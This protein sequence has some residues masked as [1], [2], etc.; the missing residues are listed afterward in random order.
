MLIRYLFFL[1]SFIG[2]SLT[3]CNSSSSSSSNSDSTQIRYSLSGHIL[4]AGNTAKDDDVNDHRAPEALE[5]DTIYTAQ[6]VNN[7]LILGG[8]VNQPWSG[9]SGRSQ[10]SGDVNDF[11][12]VDLRANQTITLFV[13]NENL[14]GNDLDLA[15]LDRNGAILNASV[16][17]G[18]T[19]NI[20][21]PTDGRYFVLVQAHSG[22]SNYVLSIGQTVTTTSR[23]VQITDDF[24]PGEIII[25]FSQDTIYQAQST[26]NTLGMQTQSTD[27]TRP[28]LYTLKK[29]LQSLGHSLSEMAFATPELKKKYETL[30]A[31]K[32][33]RQRPDIEKVYLNYRRK[34]F[35]EP[36]DRLY[37]YQWN[38]SLMNLPQ[39]W[40]TTIGDG[41]VI[42]AVVD[43][44]VLVQ[45]PDLRNQLVQGY[46]FIASRYTELDSD[47]GIDPNPDDPGDQF[48]GGS[49]FHGTHVAG[50]VAAQSNNNEGVAGAA[51]LTKIM[52][53]RVLGKGGMGVDYD[54]EQAIRF[55]AGLPN[56]SGTVPTRRADIINLSLGGP[57]Y[58]AGFQDLMNEV[59]EAGVI[60]VAAS[61]N[62]DTDSPSYPAALNNVISVGAVN[63]NKQRASYSN[64]G[65]DLD[66]MAPGGDNTPDIDGDG[67]PDSILS[68]MGTE[69]PGS[70][71]R[72]IEFAYDYAMG[73][74][75]A[76]PQMAGVISLMK[77]VNPNL[78]PQNVDELLKSGNITDD[79][80]PPGRDDTFGYGLINAQKAILAAAELNGGE[81]PDPLPPLLIVNPK[82][83]NFGLNS[84]TALL[85]L[86][87]GGSGE[88]VID[89]VTEDSGGFLSIDIS[90][91]NEY[92]IKVDRSRLTP[93]TFSAT[94]NIISNA[95]TVSIPV[96]LQV[97][98]FGVTGDAG[99][100]YI[101]LVDPGTLDTIQE[102]RTSPINGVY[103][104]R[105]DN[106][107]AGTYI[108]AAGSDFNNDGFICDVGEA[109]GAFTT[110]ERPT[111]IDLNTHRREI[112]FN[113]GFNVNFLSQSIQESDIQR[114]KRGFA[115][116][117]TDTHQLVQ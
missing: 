38:H 77:A 88:L 87:N 62:E 68:T 55:A 69:N 7:P 74:S 52:P 59:R 21:V 71:S 110:V 85:T 58:S 10:T 26:L 16:G 82:S 36:N 109:C 20:I 44:G 14:V 47:P 29:P 35:R 112:D 72:G 80:G 115:R 64:Y 46:D 105:F 103:E 73:T 60:V 113:T 50:S 81:T 104:F 61:G 86:S 13:A 111:S 41:Q 22:A 83:L 92:Q 3:G 45:H 34:A 27:P 1:M 79:L 70:R 9:P 57:D 78:T 40:D 100:H 56:D 43:T 114:P 96:I 98:E 17:E 89:S 75:M 8:Y 94:I 65:R 101:L 24:V 108:I 39:A 33:L 25:K 4:V 12:E 11:F 63:I 107:P 37:R 5:N 95:N 106:V 19:E 32:Q 53:L 54:T 66:V 2:L 76:S 99:Y 93:G 31:R 30:I 48:P 42:V 90:N 18:K 91:E 49:T 67:M 51:W 15:L 6:F 116:L 28:M 97:S 117:N 23:S 102:K 84:T